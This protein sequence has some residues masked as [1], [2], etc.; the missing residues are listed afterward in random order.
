M[1][2]WEECRPEVR[3]Y[4]GE[5]TID[6]APTSEEPAGSRLYSKND[7]A[8]RGKLAATREEALRD[9]GGD[10]VGE[11]AFEAGGVHGG[12]DVIVGGAIGDG[13]VG[14]DEQ[15]CGRRTNLDESGAA[16]GA[17]VH[18]VAGHGCGHAR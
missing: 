1:E 6:R 9:D 15:R 14:I 4:D 16:G 11:D 5:G 18:V 12:G 8:W 7:K 10:L 3:R 2:G 13:A 17:A